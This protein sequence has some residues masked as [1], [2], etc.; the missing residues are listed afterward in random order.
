MVLYPGERIAPLNPFTNPGYVIN[1]FYFVTTYGRYFS[2]YNR[3]FSE[4]HQQYDTDGY[5]NV[6]VSTNA[7]QKHVI[8]H[9]GVLATFA[10]VPDMYN[11]QVDH[12][13][14]NHANNNISNCL[15]GRLSHD[16]FLS[17]LAL[18]LCLSL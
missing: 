5:L 3:T 2:T 13:D 15:L 4:L 8:S 9:R 11:L 6:Q 1:A 17:F 14:G 12:I 7:G 10:P 16:L 18:F